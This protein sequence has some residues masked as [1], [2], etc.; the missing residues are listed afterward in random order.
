M[1]CVIP[2]SVCTLLSG[3]CA[4]D[5]DPED[6]EARRSDFHRRRFE[7]VSQFACMCERLLFLFHFV[8]AGSCQY[9]AQ[10]TCQ[11]RSTRMAKQ[12]MSALRFFRQ[13]YMLAGIVLR[14]FA[15][16]SPSGSLTLPTGCWHG[17]G[18]RWLQHS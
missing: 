2:L 16:R 18:M 3:S 11:C 6:G 7:E 15:F 5:E 13:C 12:Y 8:R 1:F 14:S 17:L 10:S 4:E 9:V